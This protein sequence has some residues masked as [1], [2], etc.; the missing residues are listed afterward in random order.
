MIDPLLGLGL[1]AAVLGL[2]VGFVVGLMS[3]PKG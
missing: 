2:I 3:C 1:G